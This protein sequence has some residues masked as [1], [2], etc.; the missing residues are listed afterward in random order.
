MPGDADLIDVFP[1]GYTLASTS[2]IYTFSKDKVVVEAVSSSSTDMFE[3]KVGLSDDALK[4]FKAATTKLVN[5]CKK[6]GSLVRDDCGIRF[7]QPSG[8]KA[9]PSTI[10][11]TPS[12]TN[13]INRM[14]PT[15]DTSDLSV[16]ASLSISWTCT[17]KGSKGSYRGYDS[18]V[19]V[20]GTVAG[21]RHLEGHR[22]ASV[23]VRDS[24]APTRGGRAV[25]CVELSG[26]RVRSVMLSL[27]VPTSG[28]IAQTVRAL[29]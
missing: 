20:Y 24:A 11:C 27:G 7:R 3:I 16:S 6:P 2:P 17:M 26:C 13:L 10:A 9:K 28:P 14:K 15:L 23:I 4:D 22:R 29:P 18:L 1:G 5:S 12:G 21:G 25:S 8:D 19:R